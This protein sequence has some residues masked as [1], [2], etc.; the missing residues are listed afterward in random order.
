METK[1]KKYYDELIIK[2]QNRSLEN[3]YVE[4]HHIIPKCL[5]GDNAKTN[6]VELTAREHYVA[7]LLLVKIYPNEYKL[8][9]AANM[10]SCFS[11]FNSERIKNRQYSWIKEKLSYLMSIYQ[12]GKNNSQYGTMW[13]S[14]IDE[15]YNK[16]IKKSDLD[17]YLNMGFVIGRNKW[18]NDNI[19]IY[20]HDTN[21]ILLI[22][23]S[24]FTI[25]ESKG[26]IKGKKVKS[27]KNKSVNNNSLIDIIDKKN[28]ANKMYE[29]YCNSNYNLLVVADKYGYIGKN[30]RIN[31]YKFMKKNS[32][33]YNLN[34]DNHI[35]GF[36]G[37]KH[38]DETKEKISK[39][40]K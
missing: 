2:A 6:L 16:K 10:M 32:D 4:S 34:K 33:L 12:G 3:C 23:S 17:Q 1:Y 40:S 38:S 24:K 28:R 25:Y 13:I 19:W 22:H 37:R 27:L 39:S 29:D 30:S 18:N 14:N 31:A 7:H 11:E 26:F 5:G 15:Q 20:N 8:V 35:K 36:T 9:I 21:E